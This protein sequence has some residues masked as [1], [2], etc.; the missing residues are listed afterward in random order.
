VDNGSKDNSQDVIR[1]L[2]M[3]S[4]EKT[5]TLFF[6]KNIYHGPAMHQVMN[7]IS[8]EYVFFLDSDTETKRHGFLEAMQKELE[9]SAITYGI[10]QHLTVNKRGFLSEKGVIILAPAYMMLRRSF[11]F[12]L[13]PFEHHG[14]PVLKNFI[15]AHRKEYSLKSFPIEDFIK[16]RWRGTSSRF[17]YGLGLR[18]KIDFLLNKIGI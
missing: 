15:A 2:E 11:Y 4:P 12:M 9:T 16:H 14:Q 6:K 5:K 17:G 8:K 10:G 7:A 3:L 13:P 18:G 1:K